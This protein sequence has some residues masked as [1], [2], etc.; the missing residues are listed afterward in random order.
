VDIGKLIGREGIAQNLSTLAGDPQ[1][2]KM[3]DKRP[4]LIVGL[5]GA[6]KIGSTGEGNRFYSV[7]DIIELAGDSGVINLA[8]EH[9][10]S[11]FIAALAESNYSVNEIKS[12]TREG[13]EISQ[14]LETGGFQKRRVIT[15]MAKSGYTFTEFKKLL[16]NP[17]M[18]KLTESHHGSSAVEELTKLGRE[19]FELKDFLND[20]GFTDIFNSKFGAASIESLIKGGADDPQVIKNFINAHPDISKNSKVVRNLGIRVS[21]E[22]IKSLIG[23]TNP[24]GNNILEMAADYEAAT[25]IEHLFDYRD[26]DKNPLSTAKVVEY[27]VAANIPKLADYSNYKDFIRSLP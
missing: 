21:I 20:S 27:M 8:S 12:L 2:R 22:N 9:N 19:K 26:E 16:K 18:I 23:E 7:D 24:D 25:A 5:L 13:G 10:I 3:V 17:T 1:V 6:I 4:F 14:F 15:A 11:D